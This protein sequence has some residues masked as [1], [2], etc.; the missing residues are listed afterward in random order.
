[1]ANNQI[2]RSEL[3]LQVW[4]TP[5]RKLA[6]KYGLSDVGLAKLCKRHDIPRLERGY[7][8]KKE[9]GKA[10]IES[11]FVPQPEEDYEIR[12]AGSK[13]RGRGASSKVS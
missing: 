12:L 9:F 7:R 3:Y 10:P 1:M 5:M 6:L 8:A 13:Q 4:S 11:T 2:M